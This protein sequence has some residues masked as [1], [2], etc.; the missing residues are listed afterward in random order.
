MKKHGG[1]RG[2]PEFDARLRG[3]SAFERRWRSVAGIEIEAVDA[4][5]RR[6]IEQGIDRRVIGAR[7]G[8]LDPEFAK[9]WKLLMVRSGFDGER[10]RRHA[11]VLVAAEKTEIARAEKGNDFVKDLGQFR[12]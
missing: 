7:L 4:G 12:G 6:A 10:P 1:Q 5:R 9:K 2:K 8:R 11:I 3:N